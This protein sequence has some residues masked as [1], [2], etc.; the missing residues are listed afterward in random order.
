MNLNRMF[1]TLAIFFTTLGLLVASIPAGFFEHQAEIELIGGMDKEVAS[2]FNTLNITAYKS[3]WDF[4]LKRDNSNV[5]STGLPDENQLEVYWKNN[6]GVAGHDFIQFIHATHD[7]LGWHGHVTHVQPP[8][9]ANLENDVAVEKHEMIELS[10]GG[11]YSYYE[12]KSDLGL[13]LKIIIAPYGSYGTVETSWNAGILRGLISYEVDFEKMKPNAWNLIGDLLFF[14]NPDFGIPGD[15]GQLVNGIIGWTMWACII[16][17]A[18]VFI[19]S[20]IPTVP[21]WPGG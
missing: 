2:Y 4:V 3:G 13:L 18:A 7:W 14:Q 19:L 8:Y 21:G 12:A 1:V 16:L 5:T 9:S 6:T 20:F 11:N 17:L 15:V 10:A